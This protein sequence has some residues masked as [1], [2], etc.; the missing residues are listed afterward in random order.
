M[1]PEL[2]TERKGPVTRLCTHTLTSLKYG[3]ADLVEELI[4]KQTFTEVLLR[5][6]LGRP[7]RPVDVRIA[8][9]ALVVLMEHGLTPSSISTRLVYMSAPENLQGAVA[10]GLLAVGS[11]F[12]GTMENCSRLIDRIRDSD[13]AR[14]EA[15]AIAREYVQARKAIPGFGHHLH[16]PVDPRAY[17]LLDLARAEPELA[18]THIETLMLLSREIDATFGRPITINATGAVAALLGEIGVATE[19]MRGFAVISRAAGLVSHVV[20]ERQSPSGRFIWETV[21]DAIPFVSGE[22]GPA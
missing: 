13:D 4:G 20:E 9:M 21:E 3:E 7:I 1:K 6:I 19:V 16:K 12:V 2:K 15:S 11:Q 17:K 14:A 5:Q 18:G 10:A 22:P 8:D